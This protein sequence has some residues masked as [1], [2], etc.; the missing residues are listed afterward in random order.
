ML[1]DM[2]CR[3]CGGYQHRSWRKKVVFRSS[4]QFGRNDFQLVIF[5]VFLWAFL[6]VPFCVE[7]AASKRAQGG[8]P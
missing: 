5:A 4:L 8:R 7:K 2:L 3:V 1:G 6:L